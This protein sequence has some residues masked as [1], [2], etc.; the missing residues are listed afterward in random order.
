MLGEMLDELLHRLTNH[1]AY[2][3]NIRRTVGQDVRL[4]VMFFDEGYLNLA[5][6]MTTRVTK[7]T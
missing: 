7:S 2:P 6:Y 4:N 5:K 1:A 3:V